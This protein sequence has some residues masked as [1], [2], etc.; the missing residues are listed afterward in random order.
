MEIWQAILAN[1]LLCA[2]F[3][4][5]FVAHVLK[6]LIEAWRSKKLELNLLWSS[7]GMPS[8]HS[9]TVCALA[10]GSAMLYGLSSFEFAM[11]A[12]FA[13]VV[14]Y[15]ASGVRRETGKQSKLLNLILE[16]DISEWASLETFDE[17]LKELVGHTPLQV[18]SGAILGFLIAW[19]YVC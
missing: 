19:Y 14:M 8:S 11:S 17:N 18:T 13:M 15:D 3:I 10:T 9:S 7:G 12:I 1:R 4:A 6:L 5:W 16:S 2:A